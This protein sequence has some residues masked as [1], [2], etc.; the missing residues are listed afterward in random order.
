ML[1]DKEYSSA[2]ASVLDAFFTSPTV[3]DGIY[4]ALENF[5]FEG[6]NVLEP[7]MGVGNF[8]GKMPDE[9]R[10]NSKL[11][12]VEIDS[13]SGRIAQ[14]FYPDADISIQGFE[15]NNFQNDSFDVA[16]G[17][18]LFGELSFKDDIHG[19][20]NVYSRKGNFLHIF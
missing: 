5:G 1:T 6:G 20:T 7:A 18:V 10:E 11:Y 14:K 12:G 9:M 2:R 3:I 8:F 15:K 16:V 19:T 17:N 13:I 4:Q